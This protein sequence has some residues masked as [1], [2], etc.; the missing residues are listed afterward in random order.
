MKSF[1]KNN[2]FTLT[3]LMVSITIL[4]VLSVW[5]LYFITNTY[6]EIL[7][8][9]PENSRVLEA[10][11]LQESISSAQQSGYIKWDYVQDKYLKLHNTATDS[12]FLIKKIDDQTI[13]IWYG[14]FIDIETADLSYKIKAGEIKIKEISVEPKKDENVKNYRIDFTLKNEQNSKTYTLYI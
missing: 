4:A 9:N 5:V 7:A 10:F 11:R 12:D 8:S 6:E 14:K 2:A 3:E 13:W 1:F